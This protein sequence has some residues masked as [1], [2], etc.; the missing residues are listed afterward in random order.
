MERQFEDPQTLVAMKDSFNCL[1]DQNKPAS[2]SYVME[3]NTYAGFSTNRQ[4]G[5]LARYSGD[6]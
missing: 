1:L 5:R 3:K 4:V 6:P 2:K